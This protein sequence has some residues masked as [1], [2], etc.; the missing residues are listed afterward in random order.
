MKKKYSYNLFVLL[1]VSFLFPMNAFPQV[2][3]HFYVDLSFELEDEQQR[4]E[5]ITVYITGDI[6]PFEDQKR[7]QMKP[8][9]DKPNQYVLDMR[10]SQAHEGRQLKY[11]YHY[12]NGNRLFSERSMQ[13]LT[14]PG[15][16]EV[17]L[18]PEMFNTQVTRY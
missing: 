16:G 2:T 4:K 1:F 15:S 13:S 7:V 11:R 17:H 8:V 14:I 10:F 5:D 12:R 3:V 6:P 9:P 18:R